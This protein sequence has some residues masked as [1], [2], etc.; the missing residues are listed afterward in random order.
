MKRLKDLI[1]DVKVVEQRGSLD[2][3]ILGLAIDSRLIKPQRAFF[4]YQGTIVDGHQFIDSAISKGAEVIFCNQLPKF[5]Q[6]NITYLQVDDCRKVVGIVANEFFDRPSENLKLAAVTGTNGKTT[7]ATLCYQ[8]F[9]GLGFQ[10]GLLSTIRNVIGKKIY[11]TTHTTNDAIQINEMLKKMVDDHCEY[12]FMEASSHAIDQ[13]RIA[14]LKFAGAVFT[15]ITHDHLDYHKTFANYI[16][17]KKK[18]FDNLPKEAFALVNIDDKRGEVM[19]QNSKAKRYTFAVKS[20][21]DYKAKIIEDS[22]A[23]LDMEINGI[24]MF[25]AMVGTFNTYNIL[26]VAGV[27]ELLGIE[28]HEALRVMSTLTGAQGRFDRVQS[29]REGIIGIV[30]YAHTPDALLNVLETIAGIKKRSERVIT[31]VGCGGDRDKA[32]RPK[33]AQI[34]V[35]LSD[36]VIITTDNPRSEEPLTIIEEMKTGVDQTQLKKVLTQIDRR[37]AIRTAVSLADSKDI[38]LIAGKGHEDY[39]EIK[40]VKYPFDDKAILRETF[41]ELER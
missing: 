19:V 23:G 13:D 30:D 38:I 2:R 27:A 5:I 28:I 9:S 14:G 32:K 33:M 8:L 29:E 24:R 40:G 12:A 6:E 22:F 17:A 31:V 36:K 16:Q 35:E 4:A 34:A 37:E 1:K 10:T 39:Q 11:P 20:F 18:L 15:N 26:A 7:V 3:S 21:A 41:K 25:S